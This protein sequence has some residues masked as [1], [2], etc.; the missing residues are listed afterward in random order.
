MQTDKRAEQIADKYLSQ[1]RFTYAEFYDNATSPFPAQIHLE[2]PTEMLREYAI[3]KNRQIP[4]EDIEQGSFLTQFWL[5]TGL[6]KKLMT[7]KDV[8]TRPEDSREQ[9]I[10]MLDYLIGENIYAEFSPIPQK[11]NLQSEKVEIEICD[12]PYSDE[13]EQM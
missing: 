3:L 7:H 11:R 5:E 9:P 1:I 13:D 4:E 12:I 8:H 10:D 6:A 2:V